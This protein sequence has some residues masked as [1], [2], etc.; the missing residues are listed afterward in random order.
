MLERGRK[1]MSKYIITEVRDVSNMQRQ[2][3]VCSY[4]RHFT[5]G[6]DSGGFSGAI[7]LSNIRNEVFIVSFYK[8]IY[9]FGS[10]IRCWIG[11]NKTGQDR[12]WGISGLSIDRVNTQ[13]DIIYWGGAVYRFL[14]WNAD[15]SLGRGINAS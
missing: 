8:T 2:N 15:F 12:F 4:D 5:S 1:L 11:I 13:S 6:D 10:F 14:G 9:F 7:L 3:I